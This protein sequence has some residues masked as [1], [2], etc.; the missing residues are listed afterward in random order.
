MRNRAKIDLQAFRIILSLLLILSATDIGPEQ[1]EIFLQ[2][3]IVP[4]Q[5]AV[6]IEP[7]LPFKKSP[8]KVFQTNFISAIHKQQFLA[9]FKRQAHV[10]LYSCLRVW[11]KSPSSVQVIAKIHKTGKLTGVKLLDLDSDVPECFR[12]AIYGMDFSSST[13]NLQGEFET[14]QWRVE[15]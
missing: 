11:K 6:K 8:G 1:I 3:E 7:P 2:P 4:E 9:S 10:S 12:K 5:E 14:I 13:A 15:W